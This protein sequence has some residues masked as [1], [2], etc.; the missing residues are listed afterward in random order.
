MDPEVGKKC[1]QNKKPKSIWWT[2]KIFRNNSQV[3]SEIQAQQNPKMTYSLVC[4]KDKVRSKAGNMLIH[5]WIRLIR[6]YSETYSN[7]QWNAQKSLTLVTVTTNHQ[8]MLCTYLLLKIWTLF[9][10]TYQPFITKEMKVAWLPLLKKSQ[11]DSSLCS[12]IFWI[13]EYEKRLISTTG[14]EKPSKK[15]YPLLYAIK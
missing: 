3:S 13:Y 4:L 15:R 10:K 2:E 8:E 11:S 14:I 12:Y 6:S 9:W 7:Q 5:K 1:G